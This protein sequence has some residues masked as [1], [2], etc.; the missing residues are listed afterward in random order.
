MKPGQVAYEAHKNRLQNMEG[1]AVGY[2]SGRIRSWAQLDN[3]QKAHWHAI[4]EAIVLHVRDT[5][6]TEGIPRDE[7]LKQ[8]RVT[9]RRL[10]AK[11]R[12][13]L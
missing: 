6:F 2:N 7:L 8:R 11:G 1:G 13:A 12:E 5:I 9:H 4:A 10:V 3:R